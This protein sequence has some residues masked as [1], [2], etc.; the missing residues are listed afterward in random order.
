MSDIEHFLS[1][2]CITAKV[3]DSLIMKQNEILRNVLQTQLKFIQKHATVIIE[4]YP[5]SNLRKF[6]TEPKNVRKTVNEVASVIMTLSIA[7]ESTLC[8]STI[9]EVTHKY[10]DIEAEIQ[11]VSDHE[12]LKTTSWSLNSCQ[13]I[14]EYC[15]RECSEDCDA[16]CSQRYQLGRWQCKAVS[17]KQTIPLD[18]VCDDKL[19][20]YDEADEIE[21]HRGSLLFCNSSFFCFIF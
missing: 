7:L 17:N 4:H 11:R 13:C 8:S 19:D 18:L 10:D 1:N 14:E 5:Q 9:D 15:V 20:C 12:S 2:K 21:C 6:Y 16:V 3:D